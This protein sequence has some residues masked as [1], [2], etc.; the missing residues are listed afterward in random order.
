METKNKKPLEILVVEDNPKFL[1]VSKSVAN[2]ESGLNIN[3]AVNYEE[4]IKLLDSKQIEGIVTDL[5]FPAVTVSAKKI[6]EK[7]GEKVGVIRG[8]D[9]TH[10]SNPFNE[11]SE[12]P[13]GLLIGEYALKKD[14]PF[15]IVSQGSRHFGDL[16]EVRYFIQAI[17]NKMYDLKKDG[18][19]RL[20]DMSSELLKYL[21]KENKE[22]YDLFL[23]RGQHA[24]KEKSEDWKDAFDYIKKEIEN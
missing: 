10:K 2:Q 24:N 11:L 16:G 12:E 17:T 15:I 6:Y 13:S 19:L 5:F 14:I 7:E 9:R 1:E 23:Y 18:K 4:A 8:R 20:N 3:Y 22:I 21:S